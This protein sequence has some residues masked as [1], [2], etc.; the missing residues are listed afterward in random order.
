MN[1]FKKIGLIALILANSVSGMSIVE[2]K[3][4]KVLT[5]KY[6]AQVQHEGQAIKGGTLKIAFVGEAFSGVLNRLYADNLGDQTIIEYFNPGLFGYN[7]AFTID[8]SGFGRLKLDQEAKTATITIPQGHKW[9][10]GQAMTI[11]DVIYPYYVIGHPDYTGIHYSESYRNIKGMEDY[12]QGKTKQI[13]GIEK[14]DDYTVVI[15]Y[16]KMDASMLQVDGGVSNLIE[17]KHILEKIAI[18]DLEGSQAVRTQPVGFG[19]FKVESISAGEAV[20]FKAN[21]YYYRGKPKLDGVLLEVVNEDTVIE[22]MKHGNY[23]LASLPYSQFDQ[24]KDAKNFSIAGRINN[25]YTYLGFKLGKWDKAKGQVIPDPKKVQVNKALRQ[26]MAYAIQTD[27]IAETFYGGLRTPA[28]TVISPNFKGYYQADLPGYQYNPQKAKE[29]LAKAGFKDRDGDG[30]VEDPNGKAFKLNFAS[31]AGG[32]TAEPVAMY[33]LQ[34]WKEIGVN[35]ALTDGRLIDGKNYYQRIEADDPK[36]DIF[37]GGWSL[38]GNPN[39]QAYYGSKE[40]FNYIRWS[41]KENDRLLAQINSPAT[42]D[43]AARTKAYADWQSY[44]MDQVPLIPQMYSNGLMAVNKRV[45]HFDYSLG[46]EMEWEKVTL[47]ADQPQA[48]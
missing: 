18:K 8:D 37:M 32:D 14:V 38:G 34:A 39:P 13:K 24:F 27:K 47:L 2:A 42:F 31:S 48:E 22:E 35:V 43:Q 19:P 30:F 7:E 6:P 21:P 12:H 26:A 4:E 5:S 28:N 17:P 46:A 1:T 29:I 20:N 36:I 45:S 41:D 44:V 23:D 9:D 3:D 33:Y 15:H 25:T 10:D 40:A 16:Q 11:D